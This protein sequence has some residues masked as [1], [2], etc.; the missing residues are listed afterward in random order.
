MISIV[1]LILG[2]PVLGI[3]IQGPALVLLYVAALL[4]LWSMILYLRA[5]W[6]SLRGSHH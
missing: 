5:A 4:T 6:P 2:G 3:S 1:L